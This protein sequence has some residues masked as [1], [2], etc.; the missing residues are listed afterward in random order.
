[1]AAWTQ[2]RDRSEKKA[3]T[4]IFRLTGVPIK[5]TLAKAYGIRVNMPHSL[6]GSHVCDHYLGFRQLETSTLPL[7]F[8][9][10]KVADVELFCST[11]KL[12][13]SQLTEHTIH[14]S[15]NYIII[16]AMRFVNRF[17]RSVTITMSTKREQLPSHPI[18]SIVIISVCSSPNSWF[19]FMVVLTIPMAIAYLLCFL[20]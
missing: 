4:E 13:E 10:L 20:E 8:L 9:P 11:N 14:S 1:M 2:S 7:L 18:S 15:T 6:A 17:R 3:Q 19:A 5:N 12:S 16:E